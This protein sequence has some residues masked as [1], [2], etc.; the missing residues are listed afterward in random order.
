MRLAAIILAFFLTSA[1]TANAQDVIAPDEL[2]ELPSDEIIVGPEDASTEDDDAVPLNQIYDGRGNV[3]LDRRDVGPK[4]FTIIPDV[5]DI[6]ALVTY[7][8]EGLPRKSERITLPGTIMLAAPG[9][10]ASVAVD[11]PGFR[12]TGLEIRYGERWNEKHLAVRINDPFVALV[13]GK[14]GIERIEHPSQFCQFLPRRGLTA[15]AKDRAEVYQS[16]SLTSKHV[17]ALYEGM[18][19]LSIENNAGPFTEIIYCQGNPRIGYTLSENLLRRDQYLQG[20]QPQVILEMIKRQKVIVGMTRDQVLL[21][22]GQAYKISK[23]R[24]GNEQWCYVTPPGRT[25]ISFNA[26]RVVKTIFY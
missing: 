1:Y 24:N 13:A 9:D 23:L 15:V 4:K 11:E 5:T 26:D 8:H 22:W 16:P 21:S 12:P 14:V 18:F 20:Q 17:G 3:I 7:S 2:P 10:E 6:E 25:F 19:V